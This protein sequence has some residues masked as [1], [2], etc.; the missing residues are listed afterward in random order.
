MRPKA[1]QVGRLHSRPKIHKKYIDLP[2]FW[3]I[4]D[5]TNT[6]HYGVGKFLTRLLNV[7]T[8]KFYSIKDLFEAVD[9]A[10]SIPTELFDEGF[11]HFSFDITSLFVNVPLNKTINIFL[12]RIQKENLVK[13]TW[14]EVP[15]KNWLNI[16][17]Q[18]MLFY[19]M[20]KFIN[21]LTV[22]RSVC[23]WSLS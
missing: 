15:W 3:R 19:L 4:I 7:L 12:H 21:I 17:A 6:P 1:A 18:K 14:G 10:S 20:M 8:K 13:K 11:R 16:H 22:Y 23:C 2:I 5:I 9:R